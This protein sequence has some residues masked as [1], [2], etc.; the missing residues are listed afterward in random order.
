[1]IKE[2]KMIAICSSPTFHDAANIPSVTAD[3]AYE[4]LQ[5]ALDRFLALVESLDDEDWD[6][7]TACAEWSVRDILA[8]QAGG[9]ASG[10]GYK[11]MFRQYKSKPKPGQLPEDAVNDRQVW[12]RADKAP[13][14]MINEL[15][16]VGAVAAQKWAYQFRLAKLITIPHPVAGKL[17]LR[18]L[19]WVI[20]SRDTWMH[21]LDICRAAGLEFKQTREHDGRIA[22][23]VMVDVAD[24]LARKFDG[25]ALIFELSGIAGGTW[26][27]GQGDQVAAIG[28]DMLEFNIFASGRYSYEEARPLMTITGDASIAEEALKNILVLY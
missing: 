4:L 21:R 15:R 5:T 7:P 17:S 20:H 26:K 3:E 16:R 19:M 22:A 12:E 6:R 28:M 13:A 25:P 9:Y 10:T 11:E 18:H 1:L 24:I 14:E 27:I 23:L 8:H 2:Q